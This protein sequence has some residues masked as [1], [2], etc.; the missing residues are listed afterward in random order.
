MKVH[1]IF[2]LSTE[3]FRNISDSGY[4]LSYL[5]DYEFTVEVNRGIFKLNSELRHK[6]FLFYEICAGEYCYY[7]LKFIMSTI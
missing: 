5:I 2:S 4:M 3:T 7:P 1:F 6:A